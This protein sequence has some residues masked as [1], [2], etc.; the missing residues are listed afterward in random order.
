MT[1]KLP[2]S[3]NDGEKIKATLR[4]YGITIAPHVGIS[5]LVLLV[6]FF[7]MFYLFEQGVLGMIVFFV[8]FTLVLVYVV[9]I[10]FL[11]QRNQVIITN[12]RIIDVEQS[13]L[14]KRLVSA[15]PY[16]KVLNVSASKKG[17]WQTIF[18]YGNIYIEISGKPIPFELYNV[19]QPF[20]VM[21][22][23]NGLCEKV[24][25][26]MDEVAQDHLSNIVA[27]VIKDI[28]SLKSTDRQVVLEEINAYFDEVS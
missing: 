20:S 8:L 7:M 19:K 15:V 14:F 23:I 5:S 22:L 1:K 26:K 25:K 21:K 4:H 3:L 13:T 10:I 9:R 16:S 24:P 27:G 28:E 18:R 11:W 12:Q 6:D 17:V 2:F